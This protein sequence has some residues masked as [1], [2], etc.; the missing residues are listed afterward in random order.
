MRTFLVAGL[1]LSL[2]LPPHAAEGQTASAS[3][4]LVI[5]S[6]ESVPNA[7]SVEIGGSLPV[8]RSVL[9]DAWFRL[10]T[11]TRSEFGQTCASPFWEPPLDCVQ[12]RIETRGDQ[13]SGGFG[14]QVEIP[15]VTWVDFRIG[16]GFSLHKAEAEQRGMETGRSTSTH[17]DE[18]VLGP[19]GS[20]SVER[21]LGSRFGLRGGFSLERY[22]YA[23]HVIDGWALRGTQYLSSLRFG[24]TYGRH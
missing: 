19:F 10:G 7:T 13:F 4:V 11:G 23:G 21:R 15:L 20:L 9:A 22:R 24:V 16:G 8:Y 12:E 1:L 5:S 18:V 6:H 14:L 2:L 3:G 17:G